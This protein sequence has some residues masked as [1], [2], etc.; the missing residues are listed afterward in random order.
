MTTVT[1]PHNDKVAGVQIPK[2]GPHIYRQVFMHS[3]NISRRVFNSNLHALAD[4]F[5]DI[6]LEELRGKQLLPVWLVMRYCEHYYRDSAHIQQQNDFI[7]INY[8]KHEK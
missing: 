6:I 7:I 1:K 5:S 8:E 3:L 4:E 2:T